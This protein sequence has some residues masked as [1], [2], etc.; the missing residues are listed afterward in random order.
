M[1]QSFYVGTQGEL[2]KVCAC[3]LKSPGNTCTIVLLLAVLGK[4]RPRQELIL[5]ALAGGTLAREQQKEN[6]PYTLYN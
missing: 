5:L 2:N 1:K 4:S 3:F 6:S